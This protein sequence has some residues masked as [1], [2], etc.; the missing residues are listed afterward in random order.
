MKAAEA[1]HAT[2][3]ADLRAA[4]EMKNSHCDQLLAQNRELFA[5]VSKK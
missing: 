5:L 3:I 1:R 4:L 2:A